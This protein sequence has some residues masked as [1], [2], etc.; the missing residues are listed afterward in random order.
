LAKW[1]SDN[2]EVLEMKAPA[3]MP[4]ARRRPQIL[5]QVPVNAR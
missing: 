1:G 3:S 5:R 2:Q 4:E